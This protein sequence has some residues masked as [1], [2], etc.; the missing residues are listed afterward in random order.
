MRTLATGHLIRSNDVLEDLSVIAD[1]RSHVPSD[2]ETTT[3]IAESMPFMG[4]RELFPASV[5]CLR[6]IASRP[7][8]FIYLSVW[9]IVIIPAVALRVEA[10]LFEQRAVATARALAALHVGVTSKT[11]AVARMQA[12]GL[13]TRQYG[14][15]LCFDEECI[16]AVIPNSRLSNA[17]FIPLAGASP[18]FYSVLTRWGFHFSSLS[19]DVRLTSGRVSSF[20]YELMLSASRFDFGDDAIV[21]RLTSQER[22]LGR[23]E[24]A[25]YSIA[26]SPVWPE[27]R[28]GV[29]LTPNAPQEL[30]D[31]AFDVKLHCL[32]SLAGCESWREVLPR[33][34]P[35]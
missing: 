28:V 14:P 4:I 11:E 23:N 17:V 30:A 35:D 21:V 2:V 3:L 26:T 7:A 12:L 15:P 13:V 24:G 25:S 18:A 6:K 1:Y 27:K 8:R 34:R 16:S 29:A 5:W 32:W 22:L 20:S 33:I 10:A 9:V 31:H 19:A